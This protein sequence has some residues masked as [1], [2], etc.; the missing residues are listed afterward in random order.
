MTIE[1]I[2]EFLKTSPGNYLEIGVYY[3]DTF[4]KIA[5]ANPT[6]KVYGI[7]PY[8]SD[9]WTGQH[10]GTVLSD[11]EHTC[12]E[13]IKAF[14]NAKIFKMTSEEFAKQLTNIE[15]LNIST[16]FIDGS[17]WYECVC[18]DID[19]AI[20]L[21]G[22]KKGLILFDDL[23]VKGV[24]DAIVEGLSKYPQIQKTDCPQVFEMGGIYSVN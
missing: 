1:K 12:N 2:N 3:G 11:A 24:R 5:E 4:F 15:D 22:S 19:L 14:S 16:V 17:H 6:H 21:I 20:K 9:G 23:H 13:K 18:V 10:R 7:D 8:I